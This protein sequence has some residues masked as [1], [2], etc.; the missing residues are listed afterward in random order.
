[1]YKNRCLG[2]RQY[3]RHILHHHTRKTVR[4]H[5]HELHTK[6][7]TRFAHSY[8]TDVAQLSSLFRNPDEKNF[9]S[10]WNWEKQEHYIHEND[11]HIQWIG[12]TVRRKKKKKKRNNKCIFKVGL[13]DH[14]VFVWSLHTEHV[15][16]NTILFNFSPTQKKKKQIQKNWEVFK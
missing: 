15:D 8:G 1:M 7:H 6:T 10:R 11:E 9:F 12:I 16:C 4:T 3:T 13:F 14:A 5:S 2:N